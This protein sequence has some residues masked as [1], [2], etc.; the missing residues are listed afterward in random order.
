MSSNINVRVTGEL[1][2]H[3]DQQINDNGLY[4]NASEYVRSLI[5][6]DLKSS[7]EAWEWL[8]KELEP[9]LRADENAFIE[10]AARDV[11]ARNKKKNK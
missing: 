3:L 9:A 11:I 4:E 6:N 1:R 10:V 7:Q 2:T 5:R 8:S